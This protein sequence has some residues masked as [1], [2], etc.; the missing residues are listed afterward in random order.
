MKEA[1]IRKVT[2]MESLGK[3]GKGRRKGLKTADGVKTM[4]VYVYVRKIREAKCREKTF[5]PCI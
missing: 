3:G 4:W 2:F 1:F 5:H